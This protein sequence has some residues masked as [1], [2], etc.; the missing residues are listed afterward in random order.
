MRVDG[1]V[2]LGVGEIGEKRSL[3]IGISLDEI[4]G[5]V[6]DFAIDRPALLAVR[7][8]TDVLS[9]LVTDARMTLARSTDKPPKCETESQLVSPPTRLAL[10]VLG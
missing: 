5:V 1:F 3:G 8:D 2:G 4:N 10:G 6:G 7:M 9:S